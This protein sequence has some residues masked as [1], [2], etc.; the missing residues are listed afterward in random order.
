MFTS[1]ISII[2]YEIS[3]KVGIIKHALISKID[4]RFEFIDHK[5]PIKLKMSPKNV[6]YQLDEVN[7]HGKS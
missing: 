2:N 1:K 3:R 4:F 6:L 5:K 7:I